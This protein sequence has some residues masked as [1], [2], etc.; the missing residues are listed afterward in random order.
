MSA[1]AVPR[2]RRGWT[3]RRK[4]L[5]A[6]EKVFGRE[7]FHKAAV[8]DIARAAGVGQGT[9]YL[10][11]PSKQA[12]FVELV[13]E[14]GHDMRTTLRRAT[15]GLATRAEVE[16][17]GY[18]AFFDFVARHPSL[19]RILRES[20]HVAPEA[21][22]DWYERLAEGYVHGIGAAVRT[23]ELR[24]VDPEL[25]AYVL[26]SIGD[27]MGMWLLRWKGETRVPD[28]VVAGITDIVLRGLLAR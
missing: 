8:F 14:M 1:P 19:Y 18:R 28:E 15:E 24:E 2:T 13:Q 11:F 9:F 6:A 16:E 26:M 5:D 7:G 27:F 12:V 17:A 22:R 4:I 21:H 3:T 23:G 10:Y 25:A 20:E